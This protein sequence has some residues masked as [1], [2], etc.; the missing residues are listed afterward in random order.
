ML[1]CGASATPQGAQ[2]ERGGA[3]TS[4][5]AGALGCGL[6]KG[7]RSASSAPCTDSTLGSSA[8]RDTCRLQRAVHSSSQH[9]CAFVQCALAAAIQ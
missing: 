5:R 3:R 2:E 9:C 8:F 4:E 1:A 7:A 6:L